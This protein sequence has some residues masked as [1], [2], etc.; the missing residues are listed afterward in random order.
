LVK[1][2]KPERK[3][4]LRLEKELCS[5]FEKNFEIFG[6]KSIKKRNKRSTPDYI[7]IG[8]DGKEVGVE[9]ELRSS[10]FYTHEHSV[11]KID[12]LIC[13]V[14]DSKVPVKCYELHG[15]DVE[16]SPCLRIG[17]NPTLYR[18]LEKVKKNHMYTNLG[19]ILHPM[20]AEWVFDK[21]K[22]EYFEVIG[23][24]L[25]E[26]PDRFE[27]LRGKENGGVVHLKVNKK[28]GGIKNGL[29]AEV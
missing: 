16:E 3:K 19:S 12:V 8:W 18:C 22:E 24:I 5:W 13:A 14:Y 4:I 11:D 10:N 21:H 29:E 17:L 7:M 26:E 25:D 23:E 15:F 2:I 20:I 1:K 27:F 6:F 9:L 28:I